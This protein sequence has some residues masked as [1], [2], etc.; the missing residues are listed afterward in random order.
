MKKRAELE[1]AA[2]NGGNKT[3]KQ[4]KVR[5]TDALETSRHWNVLGTHKRKVP[6]YVE[7]NSFKLAQSRKILTILETILY[8][9]F[10][11]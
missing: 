5:R 9:A 7:S 6:F 2:Q 10:M 1:A 3:K 11:I 4:E 8:S